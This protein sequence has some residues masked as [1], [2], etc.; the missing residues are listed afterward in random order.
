MNYFTRLLATGGLAVALVSPAS[1]ASFG[2]YVDIFALYDIETDGGHGVS[3]ASAS[4]SGL[5]DGSGIDGEYTYMAEVD[6]SGPSYLPVL[7]A[8]STNTGI[9]DDSATRARTIAYQTYT[10]AIDQTISLDINLHAIVDALDGNPTS[11]SNTRARSFI[12]VWG[13]PNFRVTSDNCGQPLF[14][15]LSMCGSQLGFSSL[16][17][18]ESDN[19]TDLP[20]SLS[21]SLSAGDTFGIYASLTATSVNGSTNAFDTLD[22]SFSDDTFID[23]VEVPGAVVPVPAAVWLFGSGLMGLVGLARRKKVA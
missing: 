19:V 1:A 7:R 18:R 16:E 15:D 17:I 11:E 12:S 21:F 20:D 10:S 3:T 2:T 22:L 5:I 6:Y 9:Y 8:K 4:G 14:E 13:D 23:V